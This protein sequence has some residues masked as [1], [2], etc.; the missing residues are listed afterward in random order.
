MLVVLKDSRNHMATQSHGLLWNSQQSVQMIYIC[1]HFTAAHLVH[2]LETCSVYF[3]STNVQQSDHN[4]ALVS[5][6][7]FSQFSRLLNL[8]KVTF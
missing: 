1:T 3:Y 5:I 4:T 8:E 6:R 7:D 2:R